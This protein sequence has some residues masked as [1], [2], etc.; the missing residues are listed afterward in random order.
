MVT[1]LKCLEEGCPP[2][3][4]VIAILDAP[5]STRQYKVHKPVMDIEYEDVVSLAKKPAERHDNC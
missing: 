5:G 2:V 1:E 4:T 3:E